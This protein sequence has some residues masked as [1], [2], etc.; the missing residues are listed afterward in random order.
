M[1]VPS[2][3]LWPVDFGRGVCMCLCVS[4][5]SVTSALAGRLRQRGVCVSMCFPNVSY[6]GSGRSTSAE[7]CVCVCVFP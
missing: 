2:H 1:P 3:W 7:G 5:M 4:L 6:I